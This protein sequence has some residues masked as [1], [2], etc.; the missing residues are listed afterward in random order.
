MGSGPAWTKLVA[1]VRS[2]SSTRDKLET[3]QYYVNRAAIWG[4]DRDIWKT[5]DYW[6]SPNEIL[7]IKSGDCEDFAIMKMMILQAAGV[8]VNDTYVTVGYDTVLKQDHAILVVRHSGAL[9]ILDERTD[10][11]VRDEYFHYF[12]PVLS[13]ND[14]HNWV[15][16]YR[17]AGVWFAPTDRKTVMGSIVL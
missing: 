3:V 16:G 6:A 1:M 10:A 5:E 14:D 11:V 7:R 4:A 13:M 8:P 9:W 15:H 17:I 2:K 12:N